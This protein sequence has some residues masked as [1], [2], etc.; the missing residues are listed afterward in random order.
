MLTI[1]VDESVSVKDGARRS[2]ST[3]ST[4]P[5]LPGVALSTPY[6]I[7]SAL[8]DERDT[9]FIVRYLPPRVLD[10]TV[11]FLLLC[12]RGPS[13]LTDIGRRRH[14]SRRHYGCL[15][16]IVCR[17]RGAAAGAVSKHKLELHNQSTFQPTNQ[18][19]PTPRS[20]HPSHT[21]TR[22]HT[23]THTHAHHTHM[24]TPSNAAMDMDASNAAGSLDTL[25]ISTSVCVQRR[26]RR[27]WLDGIRICLPSPSLN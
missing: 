24:H 7:S 16:L 13:I 5:L 6:P 2:F 19:R 15:R 8:T 3:P 18:P 22:T 21:H 14:S 20:H 27:V 26:S 11:K 12:Y 25:C 17:Q 1:V 23:L 4:P 10:T 9:R